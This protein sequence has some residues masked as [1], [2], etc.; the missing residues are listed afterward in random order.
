M[1]L[2]YSTLLFAGEV[3]VGT[4]E[5]YYTAPAGTTVVIVDIEASSNA[6][7][8]ELDVLDSG[9][10]RQWLSIQVNPGVVGSWQ[11][12]QVLN[13]GDEIRLYSTTDVLYVRITGYVLQ[14]YL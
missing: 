7:E 14:Q 2:I 10:T 1:A 8:T 6:I 5:P 12:R 11:G 9:A 4:I 13:A 3:P